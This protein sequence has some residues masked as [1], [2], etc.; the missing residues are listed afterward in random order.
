VPGTPFPVND[1]KSYRGLVEVVT[2][3]DNVGTRGGCPVH[4]LVDGG[5]KADYSQV[6]SKVSHIWSTLPAGQTRR[7]KTAS[8][9]TRPSEWLLKGIKEFHN[10]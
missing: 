10:S 8:A 3:L 6:K 7:P 9:A 1:H 4:L 2:T 5:E